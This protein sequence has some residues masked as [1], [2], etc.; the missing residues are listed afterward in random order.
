MLTY[1]QLFCWLLGELVSFLSPKLL[2][3]YFPNKLQNVFSKKFRFLQSCKV[4]T[5][6][7][8]MEGNYVGVFLLGPSLGCVYEFIREGGNASRY[9]YCEPERRENNFNLSKT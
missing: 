2:F 8:E 5:S 1:K 4:A 3:L 7:H 9:L 6:R